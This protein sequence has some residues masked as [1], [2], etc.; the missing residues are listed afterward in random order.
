MNTGGIIILVAVLLFC[1]YE[2]VSLSFTIVKKR[3]KKQCAVEDKVA[4]SN[5]DKNN[6][7]GGVA[8]ERNSNNAVDN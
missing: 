3:K 7:K 2:I 1:I 4:E 8:N 6:E 5:E